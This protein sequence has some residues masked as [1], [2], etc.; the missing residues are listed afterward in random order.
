VVDIVTGDGT[1]LYDKEL[2]P[3]L[4]IEI[5]AEK[6]YINSV[7]ESQLIVENRQLAIKAIDLNMVTGLNEALNTKA[8]SNSVKDIE[9]L[10]NAR[11]QAHEARIASLEGRLIWQPLMDENV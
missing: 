4:G 10:L 5:G 9:D 6:N 11:Y 1:G 7:N 8:S 3:L 2:K